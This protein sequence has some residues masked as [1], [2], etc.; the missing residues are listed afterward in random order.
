[1]AVPGKKLTTWF[2]RNEIALARRAAAHRKMDLG[3]FVREAV[4]LAAGETFS[5]TRFESDPHDRHDADSFPIRR[6]K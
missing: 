3:L 4:T 5:S 1:M 2:A 6:T